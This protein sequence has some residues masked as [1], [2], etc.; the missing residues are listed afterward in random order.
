MRH[1]KR[2]W[3]SAIEQEGS[4]MTCEEDDSDYLSPREVTAAID[5]MPVT[6]YRVLAKQSAFM[7]WRV[8]GM[9]GSDLLHEALVRLL[10]DRRHWRRDVDLKTTV[11]NIMVSIAKDKRKQAKEGPM[12]QYAVVTEGNGGEEED[13]EESRQKTEVAIA[14]GTP[15]A[16][17]GTREILSFLATL[18]AGNADEES[19]ALSWALGLSG[20]EAA[21]QAGITMKDYD[22]A[23]KRLERKFDAVQKKTGA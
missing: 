9:S 18:A 2:L 6:V 10:S 4:K 7:S 8:P 15:E 16:I 23:R 22:A 3:W 5:A 1:P 12:D 17:A 21:K 14:V 13:D 20:K 11:F 19:V